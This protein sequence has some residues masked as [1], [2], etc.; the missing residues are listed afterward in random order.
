MSEATAPAGGVLAGLSEELAGAVE[1]ASRSIVRV[2]ARQRQAATGVVWSADGFILTA[3][4]VLEREEDISVGLPDGRSVAAKIAGRDPGTDLAL[5][6][7][8]ASGLTPIERSPAPKVGHLVLA[9]GR[10]GERPT[11]TLGIVSM[12]GGAA[13]TRR[14][15]VLEGF[16]RTDAAMLPGFSGGPL[17]DARGRLV[18]LNTSHFGGGAGVALPLETLE[19]ISEALAK[20]G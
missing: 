17:I 1:R 14:G 12:L 5:L 16:I 2:E 20:G 13:R 18:G 11:A 9:V 7:A 6:R 8:E 15:G 19:R 10:P 4:H 3:D